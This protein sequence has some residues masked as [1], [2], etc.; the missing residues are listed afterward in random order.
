MTQLTPTLEAYFT[1]RLRPAP[2]QPAHRGLLPGR[3]QAAPGLRRAADRQAAVPAAA[4]GPR[5]PVIGAFLDHLETERGNVVRTR[6][7]RLA[8]LH[9]MFRFAALRHPEHAALIARV[10][11]IPPKRTERA[12]VSS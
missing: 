4:R 6:N 7:A 1:V 12:N 2:G 3:L 9:S 11:A 5:R 8:A 10:L